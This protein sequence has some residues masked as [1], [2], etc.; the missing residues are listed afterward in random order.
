MCFTRVHM[1]DAMCVWR[2]YA[3]GNSLLLALLGVNDPAEPDRTAL[4][5]MAA[6]HR[7]LPPPTGLDK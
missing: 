4:L 1:A 5:C 2:K 3:Y 7:T 6:Q